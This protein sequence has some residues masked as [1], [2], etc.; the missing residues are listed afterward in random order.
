MNPIITT[1]IMARGMRSFK[2]VFLILETGPLSSRISSWGG[3]G[4]PD[5]GR[6]STAGFGFSSDG[7]RGGSCGGGGEEGSGGGVWGGGGGVS[8][9]EGESLAEKISSWS[10]MLMVVLVL[11]AGMKVGD[12]RFSKMFNLMLSYSKGENDCKK[13][14]EI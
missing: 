9:A 14:G 11:L 1:I 6:P 2:R 4:G 12:K 3:G 13:K 8:G 10:G 5:G 7:D